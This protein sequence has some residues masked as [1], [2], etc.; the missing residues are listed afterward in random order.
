MVKPASSDSSH[1][2]GWR[3]RSGTWAP[4]RFVSRRIVK[5]YVISTDAAGVAIRVLGVGASNVVVAP[6]GVVN[7]HE[8]RCPRF[9]AIQEL[10]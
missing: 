9:R 2:I 1:R 3:Y 10:Y 8:Q 4:G 7:D 6:V 5:C